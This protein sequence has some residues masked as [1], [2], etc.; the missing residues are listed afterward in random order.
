[1]SAMKMTVT[2]FRAARPPDGSLNSFLLGAH[3]FP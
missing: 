1:M 3:A 2:L